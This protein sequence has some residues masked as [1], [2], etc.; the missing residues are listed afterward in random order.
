L[1]AFIDIA[2]WRRGFKNENVKM[3]LFVNHF[4][5]KNLVKHTKHI[6]RIF[7]LKFVFLKSDLKILFNTNG[8]IPH[9]LNTV[10]FFGIY[11]LD[12]GQFS[13]NLSKFL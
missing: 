10:L 11:P 7:E 8:Q 3:I 1:F 12:Y 9:V 2:R 13:R 5:F 4:L 6:C